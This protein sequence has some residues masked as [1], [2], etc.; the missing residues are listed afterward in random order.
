MS[1]KLFEFAI[2]EGCEITTLVGVARFF[3]L[4]RVHSVLAVL[5]HSS[6]CIADYV[7]CELSALMSEGI[8]LCP[9]PFP[10]A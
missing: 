5:A 8:R 6:G 1:T 10:T 7:C 4:C 9:P 3:P 2:R